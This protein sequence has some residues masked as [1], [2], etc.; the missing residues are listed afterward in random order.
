MST[1]IRL[2]AGL[3]AATLLAAGC[4]PARPSGAPPRPATIPA[5]ASGD[6]ATASMGLAAPASPVPARV[7]YRVQ[8]TLPS[9]ATEAAAYRLGRDTTADRVGRLAS[10]LG[11]EGTVSS[12]AQGWT[13]TGGGSSLHVERA[14]GLPW[15]LALSGGIGVGSSGCAIAMPARPAPA[16]GAP[17]APILPPPPPPACA[18]P[19]PVPGLPSRAEAEQRAE[20]ALRAAGLDL[21]GAAVEASGGIGDWYVGVTPSVGGVPMSGAGWSV[22]VGPHGDLVSASG[23]LAAPTSAGDYP[24]VGVHAG[25]DR[26]REGGRWILRGGPGPVPLLGVASGGLNTASSAGSAP[27]ALPV[28]PVAPVPLPT[29][30]APGSGSITPVP[31]APIPATVVTVTGVH[32]GLAWGT[33]VSG[34]GEAW[35]VPVYV[36]ELSGAGTVPVLAVA[37]GL[38]ATS[39]AI[40]PGVKILPAPAP[41]LPEGTGPQTAP[42]R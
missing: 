11:V 31:P 13:V 35:L 26:L 5:L 4:G 12:D 41:A 32:L 28:A 14:A 38:L 42:N 6:G 37:D 30:A 18:Q 22:T 15:Q 23:W 21:G 36:F 10:A 39:P 27:P 7:E 19:T 34:A 29:R 8:G 20:S 24:L 17:P 1:V 40:P 25:L 3:A 16:P 9:L 33:P 2:A